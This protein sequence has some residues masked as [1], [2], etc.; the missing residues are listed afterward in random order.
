MGTSK[1]AP[2]QM[3]P[4]PFSLIRPCLGLPVYFL[5]LILH[6]KFYKVSFGGQNVQAHSV[7]GIR[8][9]TKLVEYHMP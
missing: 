6:V 3:S 9:D 4:M 1:G 2:G 5:Q 7:I 8:C